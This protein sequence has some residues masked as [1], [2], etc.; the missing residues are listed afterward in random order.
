MATLNLGNATVTLRIAD[1]PRL[2]TIEIISPDLENIAI[3]NCPRLVIDETR[4]VANAPGLRFMAIHNEGI[5]D[6]IWERADYNRILAATQQQASQRQGM[7]QTAYD[8]S[9]P[10]TDRERYEAM[11]DRPTR[12]VAAPRRMRGVEVDREALARELEAM[13]SSSEDSSESSSSSEEMDDQD[14]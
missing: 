12:F 14:W 2:R 3:V 4:F 9:G 6:R 11:E 1:C 7:S 8:W 13:D 10:M 5:L